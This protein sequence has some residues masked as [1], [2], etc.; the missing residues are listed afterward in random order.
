MRAHLVELNSEES[1]EPQRALNTQE[2]F[3]SAYGNSVIITRDWVF[4]R[5][6]REITFDKS[7]TSTFN[8]VSWPGTW[9]LLGGWRVYGY[10]SEVVR[11]GPFPV[12]VKTYEDD[13]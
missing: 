11:I 13:R 3:I 10:F 9:L 12:Y 8:R 7:K 6:Q 2:A 5:Y 1:N 4:S